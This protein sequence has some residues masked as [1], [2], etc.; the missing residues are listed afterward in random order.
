MILVDQ[1]IQANAADDARLVMQVH[2][3]LVLEVK[4]SSLSK[5]ESEVR[6]LME[7]AADLDVP[8]IAESGHGNNWGEAH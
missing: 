4:T 2:D 1:W 5:V 7:S 3:E 6:K 8:L